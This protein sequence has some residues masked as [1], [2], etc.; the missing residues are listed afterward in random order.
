M[1]L[2]L[3]LSGR[4]RCT[5]VQERALTAAD[6]VFEEL[7]RCALVTGGT[8]GVG[9]EVVRELCAQGYQV[10]VAARNPIYGAV[11]CKEEE[12]AIRGAGG[13]G[14]CEFVQCDVARLT[15]VAHLATAARARWGGRLDVL[16]NNAGYSG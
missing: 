12:R 10:M 14:T 11:C 13:Q 6:E 7:P 16:V 9:R 4:G 2:L 15:Q 1:L 8:R 5:L 3:L